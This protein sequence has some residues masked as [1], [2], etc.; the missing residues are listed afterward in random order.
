MRL[1]NGS[2]RRR[3]KSTNG[4]PS[5]VPRPCYKDRIRWIR[6]IRQPNLIKLYKSL[7][8]WSTSIFSYHKFVVALLTLISKWLS[9]Q[10]CMSRSGKWCWRW[11]FI[12][13][14]TK[15]SMSR[16]IRTVRIKEFKLN[17]ICKWFHRNWMWVRIN[18]RQ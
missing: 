8:T 11:S 17:R 16:N 5:I 4:A 14:F 13:L 7:L 18:Y 2:L 9:L 12:S 6:C 3:L 1:Y 10:I 15:N